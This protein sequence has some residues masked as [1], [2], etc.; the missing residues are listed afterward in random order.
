MNK[1]IALSSVFLLLLVALAGCSQNSAQNQQPVN[2][3]NANNTNNPNQKGG[4][5]SRPDFGQ[6]DRT[7][8]VRGIVKSITGNEVDI[9]KVEMNRN[10][11]STPGAKDGNTPATG[12]ASVSLTGAG[13]MGGGTPPPGGGGGMGFAGGGPGGDS[14]GSRATMLETL[15]AM[16]TGEEKVVIP[17]G[18]KMLKSSTDSKSR[19]MVEANLSDI[20]ADKTI[21]IWLNQSVTDKK[22]AEFVLIN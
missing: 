7:A 2:T 1:K 3:D 4:I 8:D 20:A 6:P 21:T 18:I 12:A 22:V 5:P 15:K 10:A 13:G 9:L 11:S 19:E 14:A 17:V 16:S